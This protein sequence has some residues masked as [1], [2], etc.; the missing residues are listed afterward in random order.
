MSE[1]MG[2]ADSVILA[3][4]PIG[5][6][7]IIVAAIRVSGPLWLKALVGRARENVSVAE[8]ELM[9]STSEEVC[10][11]YNGQSIVRCQGKPEI[12]EFILLFKKCNERASDIPPKIDFKTLSEAVRD[13]NIVDA[14]GK[15]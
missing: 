12:W 5:I 14:K 7:T 1:A 8:M 11:L 15:S 2:W 9:S 10:E 6:L 13:G 4:A 3:M